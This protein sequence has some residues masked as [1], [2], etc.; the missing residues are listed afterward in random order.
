MDR[1]YWHKQTAGQPLFPDLLWSR[2][3]NKARAG[4][5]LIVGGNV[6]GFAAAGEAYSH[7]VKAG[8]GTARVLLPDRLQKTVSKIFPEAEFAS[9]TP[10]GSFSR[11]ALAELLELSAW[12]DGILFAGD[13]G[14]NSETA[15]LLESS[16]K[17]YSG[18]LTLAKDAVDYFTAAPQTLINRENTLLVLSFAQLQKLATSNRF[19]KAFTFEM[20]LLQLVE[21]LHEFTTQHPAAIIV[22]HLDNLLVAY[23]GQV[24]STKLAEDKDIWRVRTAAHAVTWW[25]QNPTKTFEALTV[26]LV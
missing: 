17:K 21:N 14:R 15:I 7:A 10:S 24:S 11:Q 19:A 8:I 9:S 20:G 16:I 3:E 4:K 13:F 23:G 6:H 26:S 22:K 5:L 25:L 2:P 1:T 12:A 18:Q